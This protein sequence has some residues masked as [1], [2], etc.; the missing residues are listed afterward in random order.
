M[1][2]AEYYLTYPVGRLP[3]PDQM[4]FTVHYE[5][6]GKNSLQVILVANETGLVP[7]S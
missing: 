4:T 3:P 5:T 2:Q 6:E 1:I 7:S